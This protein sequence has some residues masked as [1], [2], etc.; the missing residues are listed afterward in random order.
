MFANAGPSGEPMATP[1]IC[2]YMLLLK[3]NSTEEVA[4]CINSMKMS[5]GK[6]GCD[7]TLLL[8]R[9]SAQILYSFSKRNVGEE[10]GNVKGTEE[11]RG[12]GEG[13]VSD[14]FYK[15]ER[16]RHAVGG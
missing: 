12:G 15:G 1:S 11:N 16:I 5:R 14:F 7:K 9:A 6:D 10:A 2:R 3:L 13:K 8:Y 4:S